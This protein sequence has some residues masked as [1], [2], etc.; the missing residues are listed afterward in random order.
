MCEARVLRRMTPCPPCVCVHSACPVVHTHKR[1]QSLLGPIATHK[2]I[3]F[4]FCPQ[5]L[6]RKIP[7]TQKRVIPPQT[8]SRANKSPSRT[9]PNSL[10]QLDL[11]TNRVDV[12]VGE[13]RFR[14]VQA[15]PVR[16]QCWEGGSLPRGR[17]RIGNLSR[18]YDKPWLLS[19]YV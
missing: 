13:H 10:Q 18:I 5:K 1:T 8:P 14:A 4:R 19:G 16:L 17:P 2:Q 6:H 11:D 7:G 12:R 3:K 15:L 9:R